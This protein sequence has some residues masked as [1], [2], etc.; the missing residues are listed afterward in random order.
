MAGWLRAAGGV[1]V[2]RVAC[3]RLAVGRYRNEGGWETACPACVVVVG[4]GAAGEGG[5]GCV[6]EHSRVGLTGHG[7]VL[8]KGVWRSVVLQNMWASQGGWG[9]SASFGEVD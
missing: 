9:R 7:D 5:T 1:W 2:C 6:R 4:C 3:R 8:Q